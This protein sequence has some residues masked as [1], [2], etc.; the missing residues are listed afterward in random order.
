MTNDWLKWLH[1]QGVQQPSIKAFG[2]GLGWLYAGSEH[3]VSWLDKLPQHQTGLSKK[4]H[5]LIQAIWGRKDNAP[6]VMDACAGLGLD[7]YLMAR[8]GARIL[9]CE[10][11]P[12]I[13]ALL[14]DAYKRACQNPWYGQSKISLVYGCSSFMMK[15]WPVC[16]VRP[17][18]IYL[19][20]MFE[21]NFKGQ[22]K[23][24]AVLLKSLAQVEDATALFLQALNFTR[25]KVVVK[26]PIQA[27]YLNSKRPTYEV[28][29]KTTRYDIYQVK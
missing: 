19:D 3:Q 22:V 26:R 23:A 1:L 21:T 5:K 16:R 29:G 9:A 12:E 27:Q 24:N 7:T 4:H 8:S 6:F 2:H 25:S 13:Y 18:V 20:P 17:D 11:N 28:S 10:K 14:A 15:H